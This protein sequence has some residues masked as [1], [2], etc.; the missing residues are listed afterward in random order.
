MRLR[1]PSKR[2]TKTSLG[3][4]KPAVQGPRISLFPFKIGGL[5]LLPPRVRGASDPVAR[6]GVSLIN[7]IISKFTRSLFKR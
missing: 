3:I 2:A 6:V 5:R 7:R 4:S 1:K